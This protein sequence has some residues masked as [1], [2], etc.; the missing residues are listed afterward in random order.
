[1][2]HNSPGS[3]Q[4]NLDRLKNIDFFYHLQIIQIIQIMLLTVCLISPA[5]GRAANGPW[6]AG[7]KL[8]MQGQYATAEQNLID[9]FKKLKS[10]SDRAM[11]LKYL[12]I[13]QYMN[14]KQAAAQKSFA[15][16]LKINPRLQIAEDEVADESVIA[17]FNKLKRAPATARAQ[18]KQGSRPAAKSSSAQQTMKSVQ[19][20]KTLFKIQ[21]NVPNAQVFM[22][23]IAYGTVNTDMEVQPGTIVFDISANGYLKKSIK[24][25]I[26]PKTQSSVTVDLV[27]IQPKEPPKPA[28]PVAVKGPGTIPL[29]STPKSKETKRANSRS[30]PDAELF[31]DQPTDPYALPPPAANPSTP[32]QAP[33]AQAQTVI[34]PQAPQQPV[35]PPGAYMTSP[36][37]QPYMPPQQPGYQAYP[38]PMQPQPGYGYPAPQPYPQQPYV[39]YPQQPYTPQQPYPQQPYT[40]YGPQP[41]SQPP[42]VYNPYSGYQAPQAPVTDPYGTAPPPDPLGPGIPPIEPSGKEQ[43][44]GPPPMRPPSEKNSD[45]KSSGAKTAS[46]DC[47]TFIKLLP[48]GAGQFCQGSTFKGVLY[49]GAQL[50]GLYFYKQNSDAASKYQADLDSLVAERAADRSNVSSSETEAYDAETAQKQTDGEAAISKAQDNAQMSMMVFAGAWGISVIDAVFFAPKPVK[51]KKK[52]KLSL[53]ESP[54]KTLIA[55]LTVPWQIDTLEQPT[56]LSLGL[57]PQFNLSKPSRPS[58]I[59]GIGFDL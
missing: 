45:R 20:N 2:R 42:S 35:L 27:K 6:T 24:V 38:Q 33:R 1:M 57:S 44:T 29:P 43:I 54:H 8:T 52:L 41:Y 4:Q 39:P 7:Q 40:P 12:G 10:A 23:G 46:K 59:V 19:S 16:A 25:S 55:Q 56:S 32:T 15:E 30:N 13:A 58:A 50:G 53:F 9:S 48:F 47:S 14:K 34:P 11:T 49:A 37:Q 31:G 26:K 51:T 28:N 17:F 5:I 36:Y 21:C 18:P 22:D 3:L